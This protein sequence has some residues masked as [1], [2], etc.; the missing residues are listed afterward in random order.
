MH[1]RECGATLERFDN[2]HLLACSGLTLQE[3]AIRHHVPLDLLLHPDQIGGEESPAAYQRPAPYPAERARATLAGLRMAGLLREEG[4]FVVVP[5]EVRRLDLLLSDL[6]A[7]REYGFAF[8]QE[9]A[10]ASDTHRV[11]ARNVLKVPRGFLD[12]HAAARLSP[13]APPDFLQTLA[14]CTAHVAELHGGYLHMAFP[15]APQA[16]LVA[17]E[18]HRQHRIR[19]KPLPGLGAGLLL[20]SLT[21]EDAERLLSLLED[22]L[23]EMPGAL[24]RFRQPTPRA[25][26]VKE[27]VFDAAHFITDHPAKCSNLHGG[28]YVLQV[29]VEDRVDPVTGCVIDYGYLK[30]VVNREVVERFDHHTLNYAA[31]ELAWRSSTEM[32]CV[33]IWERL[34]EYL[35]SLREVCLYE[36][37]QS[38]CRYTGP[39]L[40]EFQR[41]GPDR[42]TGHFH[43]PA[44]GTSPLRGLLGATPHAL[45]VVAQQ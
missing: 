20:R 44:L 37:S 28:R 39:S 43:A 12:E 26:V 36:T 31:G 15:E 40:A 4:G 2:A 18:L 5:G 8:R 25:A 3:Y 42:I 19:F 11:V 38:W 29:S 21:P 45:R 23:A 17:G 33:Y 34:I 35:P 13:M 27:L 10:Y 30:R 24:A 16:E 32:L 6:Q 14:V 1:C 7:L 22:R 9:Y 41:A